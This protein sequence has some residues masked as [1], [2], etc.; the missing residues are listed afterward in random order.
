MKKF[1]YINS[2]NHVVHL[3][4]PDK[5]QITV[6]P[7]SKIILSEWFKKY[8]P[9][10]LR[11]LREIKSNVSVTK[12]K[13]LAR[14][15]HVA[16]STGIKQQR[17]QTQQQ[18]Q[19]RRISQPR[20]AIRTRQVSTRI[21]TNK[22]SAKPQ[23]G[24]KAVGRTARG[25]FSAQFAEA[26]NK[27]DISISNNV[28]VGILSYNR[29]DSLERLLTSISNNTDLSSVTVFVSDESTNKE[30]IKDVMDK[31]PKIVY[32]NNSIRLGVAGNSNRLLK[33]LDRFEYKF[34]L[35]D[36]VE[37]ISPNWIDFY[38]KAMK[39]TG[40]HHFCLREPGVY[41]AERGEP[42]RVNDFNIVTVNEKPHGAFL[43]FDSLAFKTVGYFDEKFGFYGMEHVDWSTR[44]SLSGIQ[45]PGFHD[46]DGSLDFVKMHQTKSVVENRSNLL[47]KAR[48][49]FDSVNKSRINVQATDAS[50]VN[51][52]SVVIPYRQAD[53]K[54]DLVT[55]INN[56]RAMRF[57]RIEIVLSEQDNTQKVDHQQLEPITYHFVRSS[58]PEQPF[59]KSSAFNF[60][61]LNSKYEK[62]I[63]QDA[64]I[65]ADANYTAKVASILDEFDSCHVGAKVLYLDE[66]SSHKVN[67]VKKFNDQYKCERVVGYFEGGSLGCKKSTY[68][69]IGG[70]NDDYVGY[71]IEDCDFYERLST[72]T[73]FNDNRTYNFFHLHHGRVGGWN[74]HHEANKRTEA[75]LRTKYPNSKEYAAYLRQKLK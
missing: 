67:A 51:S 37:I 62:I 40:I 70:F 30:A 41:S 11:I 55:I 46:A 2:S 25:D 44:I 32:I 34:L 31:F 66:P 65:M 9:S 54:D 63:L 4:G 16:K 10:Y 28:G 39:S 29:P 3:I 36:D 75:Q 74:E 64:D 18:P 24:R 59:N 45:L 71:G 69:A 6:Q 61:V 38:I 23:R 56:V 27:A 1:E 22:Q 21:V 26:Y 73:K 19:H 14:V 13:P 57:P 7:K 5:S 20:P 48:A 42:S 72:L 52:V 68:K 53:R 8:A 49:Y 35:N 60:G 15:Q 33:C 12:I 47:D 58:F 50:D 43:V 17:P